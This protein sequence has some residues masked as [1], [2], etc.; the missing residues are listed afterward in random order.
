MNIRFDIEYRTI[1]GEDLFLNILG[2]DG[3][4]S[5]HAMHTRDGIIW[6][7]E[8]DVPQAIDYYYTVTW[9]GREKRSIRYTY[10]VFF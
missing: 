9:E 6:S 10:P 5:P 2:H 3:S 8:L 7:I 4:A 1:Y